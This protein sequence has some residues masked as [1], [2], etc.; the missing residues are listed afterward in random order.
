M[1]R[2][3]KDGTDAPRASTPRRRVAVVVEALEGR[4]LLSA[5]AV[6]SWKM[7]PRVAV[8]PKGGE[9]AALPNTPEYVSPASGYQVIL[10][11]S[12]T[13]GARPGSSY[14]WTVKKAGETLATFSGKAPSIALPEGPYTV[15]LTVKGAKGAKAPLT[16][17][18]DIEV[19]SVLIVSIGDSYAS[20]EGNPV[21]NGYYFIKSAKWAS[22]PD[23]AMAIQNSKAH[24]STLS[25]PALFAQMLQDQDPHQ[26]VTFVSVANSGATIDKG[27]LGP[28]TSVADTSYILP[29]EVDQVRQIVGDEPIDVLL[30]SIGG[31]DIGFSTRMKQLG[32][33][34]ITGGTPLKQIRKEV[35]ADLAALPAKYA[36]LDQAIDELDPGHV[37]ITQYPDMT[38][39]QKGEY[40]P[41]KLAGLSAISKSN[42]EF[43]DQ[44]I[45]VPLNQAISTAAAT[46]GWTTV[47]NLAEPFRTHGYSSTDSWF[48][49]V[50]ES[51]KNESSLVGAFHPNLKGQRA[52]ADAIL[53][54]YQ[55]TVGP[56]TA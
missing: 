42:V 22:S 44:K 38:R 32:S 20:G 54:T 50:G 26:A 41:I 12:K 15:Q 23:P 30:V 9:I 29:P 43:A 21:R 49:D 33:N 35:N 8:V 10:D 1:P 56:T 39:N 48:V 40:A 51:L 25:A 55:Q 14:D 52:V 19:K 53:A 6:I 47:G 31:N 7:A 28:M 27:L 3:P 2:F 5:S 34:S 36:A 17:S 18:Q 37:L 24:R 46:H 13:P 11:G 45:L 4:S 16:A